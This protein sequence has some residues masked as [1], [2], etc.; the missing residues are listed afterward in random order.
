MSDNKKQIVKEGG[1]WYNELGD[2]VLE[3]PKKSGDGWKKTTLREARQM[4]LCP[5]VTTICRVAASFQ[6]QQWQLREAIM[7]ALTLPRTQDET[8]DSWLR[9]IEDDMRETARKAA[10]L[11]TAIHAA[12][13]CA[14]N[15]E[16]Y[17]PEYTQHVIGVINL[18][19]RLCGLGVEWQSEKGV[20]HPRGFGTKADLC[21]KG[22][23]FLIDFKTC[24][25]DADKLEGKRTYDNHHMQLAATRA[26]LES[27]E[28]GWPDDGKRTDGPRRQ[29]YI[30]W[31]SRT[32]PGVVSA[33]QVNEATLVQ[34]WTQFNAL[35]TY[36]QAAN[37]YKPS[38]AC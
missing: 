14:I 17:D 33:T 3:V 19:D 5:G 7:S 4:Q 25:G 28:W 1:H 37:K 35:L 24:D 8:E 22:G 29:C 12:V 6:L 15:D 10:E 36:W 2:Q 26:A 9:R 21:D 32:H 27:S 23:Q 30:V 31:I 16:P 38:W 34:G 11:G 18:L 13:E 20:T